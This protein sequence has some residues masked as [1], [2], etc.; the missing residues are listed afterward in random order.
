ML[1][2]HLDKVVDGLSCLDEQN[3]TSWP[4]EVLAKFLDRVISL[5]LG[6]FCFIGE[7]II[8]LA[9]CAVEDTDLESVVV[10]VED[11]VLAHDGEADETDITLSRHLSLANEK[12]KTS[13]K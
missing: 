6:A 10:H 3:H 12:E 8:D 13:R 5:D 11:E 7:E 1:D 2:D 4:L 9:D